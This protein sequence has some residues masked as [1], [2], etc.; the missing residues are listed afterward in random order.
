MTDFPREKEKNEM[1]AKIREGPSGEKGK[2]GLWR[3]RQEMAKRAA[4]DYLSPINISYR[5]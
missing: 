1:R 5:K 2:K 4:N 3:G